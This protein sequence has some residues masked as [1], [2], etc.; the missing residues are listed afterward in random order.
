MSADIGPCSSRRDFEPAL[1]SN[2]MQT[3]NHNMIFA[4]LTGVVL[5]VALFTVWAP[6]DAAC[7]ARQVVAILNH[8]I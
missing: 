2:T 5:A 4:C 6:R 1:R 7:E 3:K 8:L